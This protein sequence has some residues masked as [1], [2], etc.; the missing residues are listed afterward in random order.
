MGQVASYGGEK[1]KMARSD[2]A[3]PSKLRR[4]NKE[5]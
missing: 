3:V 4:K 1:L 5:A 2:P